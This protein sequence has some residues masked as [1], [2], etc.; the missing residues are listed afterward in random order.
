MHLMNTTKSE[1]VLAS[2][3]QSATELPTAA[4]PST[5]SALATVPWQNVFE[6][7][8]DD[9]ETAAPDNG[10]TPKLKLMKDAALTEEPPDKTSAHNPASGLTVLSALLIPPAAVNVD[11]RP[12][13]T[14]AETTLTAAE[15]NIAPAPSKGTMH[16]LPASLVGLSSPN[17]RDCSITASVFQNELPIPPATSPVQFGIDLNPQ[18]VT[19]GGIR[20][21]S[22]GQ[23]VVAAP[24]A[25][26]TLGPSPIVDTNPLPEM[27]IAEP[28]EVGTPLPAMPA[29]PPTPGHVPVDT[30]SATALANNAIPQTFSAVSPPLAENVSQSVV[31]L[32][33]VGGGISRTRLTTQV[34]KVVT[35]KASPS[36]AVDRTQPALSRVSGEATP[37][38]DDGHEPGAASP[39][40]GQSGNA[41][42]SSDKPAPQQSSDSPAS[43]KL[44]VEIPPHN[45]Q[46][47]SPPP[48]GENSI[49]ATVD[50]KTTGASPHASVPATIFTGAGGL[51][52]SRHGSDEHPVDASA[53]P[54]VQAPAAIGQSVESQKPQPELQP[55]ESARQLQP[56]G[57]PTSG[58]VQAAQMVERPGQVE[59]HI[60]LRTQVFGSVEIHT[61]VRDNQLGL[62][63][64]NE[65][66]DLRSFLSA[67]VPAL[68]TVAGQH[69]LQM[70]HIRYAESGIAMGA[71]FSGGRDAHPHQRSPARAGVPE[72]LLAENREEDSLPGEINVRARLNVR[73]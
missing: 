72:S 55:P 31:E 27:P 6:D 57:A 71:G 41:R 29:A 3:I 34:T 56:A 65:R 44:V 60:D 17:L 7:V 61:A 62:S 46:E 70:G 38:R 69:D 40:P 52:M 67:E 63:L 28:L 45:V 21:L 43:P 39:P 4:A 13:P 11:A 1:N 22:Q 8:L 49:S 68:Q 23:P 10:L 51:A 58:M 26:I 73:V 47:S 15:T 30:P 2:L 9:A 59:M 25:E 54:P 42:V 18:A 32:S 20:E 19:A 64:S 37:P 50:A 48:S 35:Q 12:L 53:N 16:P 24:P 33:T 5:S 14:A 36:P 66:G